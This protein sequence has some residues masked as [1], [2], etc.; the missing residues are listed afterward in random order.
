MHIAFISGNYPSQLYPTSGTFVKEFVS[1][2]A[3]Q[4]NT[5]SVVNPVSILDRR[6]GKLPPN[7]SV[8]SVGDSKISIYRPRYMSFSSHNLGFTHTGRWSNTS[9]QAASSRV[10]YALEKR[11]DII[12]GHF[13]YPSGNTSISTAK[14]NG[15]PSVVGVGEGE[16][17]TIEPIGF[18]R[19]TMQMN[20]ATAFLA[21]STYIAEELSA[22]LNVLPEKIRVFPNGVALDVF[23]PPENRFV[24]CSELGISSETFNV[25]YIGPFI[26]QKGYPQLMDAVKDIEN[27][28]LVLLGRGVLP[29]E[30]DCIAYRGRVNHAEVPKYLGTCKI[31]VLPTLIEGSCNAVIEAMAC[32]LPIVTSNGH[33]MDD[34]VDDDV[35]IRVDPTD[36]RAI[37]EAILALK[38]DPE[39]RMRM[40]EA[41]L[42]KANQFDING[43]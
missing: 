13:M 1:G 27:V 22:R 37:R 28:R 23:R 7:K 40:S 2:M 20:G 9:F 14:K 11:P 35:A 24:V 8:E 34:I 43:L 16:F 18:P 29:A 15:V 12:Y 39:R 25:G 10:I 41:C 38:N 26:F 31:F 32:G 3:R 6:R 33:Y 4:G 36:V 19:A 42:K 30:N 21:V 5:C 17:W